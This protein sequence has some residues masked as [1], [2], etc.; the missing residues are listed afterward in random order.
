MKNKVA[1]SV[2]IL[3]AAGLGLA[4]GA[5]AAAA[6]PTSG[7]KYCA[8]YD[9]SNRCVDWY[10]NEYTCRNIWNRPHDDYQIARCLAWLR[11]GS[12]RG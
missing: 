9:E 5:H 12:R 11:Y 6:A 4:G 3:F 8:Y 2:F 10:P 7:D 1:L